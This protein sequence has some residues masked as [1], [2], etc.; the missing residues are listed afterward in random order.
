MSVAACNVVV[1]SCR[2]AGLVMTCQAGV[3]QHVVFPHSSPYGGILYPTRNGLGYQLT[4]RW[5]TRLLPPVGTPISQAVSPATTPPLQREQV[6][7][8]VVPMP[9]QF[10]SARVPQSIKTRG[11]IALLAV[12]KKSFCVPLRRRPRVPALT[13]RE[14]PGSSKA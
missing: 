10:Y 7:V 4:F 2:W 11:K 12:I 13:T 8:V 5:K 14:G 1:S 3:I 9:S 6:T